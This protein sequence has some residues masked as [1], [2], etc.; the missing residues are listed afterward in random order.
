LIVNLPGSRRGAIESLEVLEAI[1]P[2]A[3]E[4]LAGPFDHQ[5]AAA[6]G[7]IDL[8]VSEPPI[9]EAG[10]DHAAHHDPAHH[11]AAHADAAHADAAHRE[12]GG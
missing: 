11:D 1:L 5:V 4:T 6:A 7:R 3:L 9:D 8:P 2:H 10:R 12:G